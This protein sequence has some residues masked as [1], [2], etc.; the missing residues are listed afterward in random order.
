MDERVEEL[1]RKIKEARFH[2]ALLESHLKEFERGI[3][4][5]FK[6]LELKPNKGKE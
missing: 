5:L 1:Q 6:K 3:N 4:A 2:V